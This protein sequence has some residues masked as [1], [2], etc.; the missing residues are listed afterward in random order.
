MDTS[1][2]AMTS[3][4]CT[5]RRT[6]ALRSLMGLTFVSVAMLLSSWAHAQ[7]PAYPPEQ[8]KA[9]FLY[10]FGAYVEWP[11]DARASGRFTI[12]VLGAESIADE[13]RRIAP[14]RTVAD[15]PVEIRHIRSLRELREPQ[16]L[17]VGEDASAQLPAVVAALRGRPVLVVSE[18]P[19]ALKRG[20]SINFTLSDR[21]VRF[22]VSLPQA[23]QAGIELSSRLL[24]VALRV[25]KTGLLY[26]VW[27]RTHAGIRCRYGT[28]CPAR[29]TRNKS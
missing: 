16:I 22:E 10:H 12:T 7:D 17:F 14:G 20:A 25:E 2:I 13:L 11:A 3:R 21:R 15:R 4:R 29:T 18:V 6:S 28:R 19:D 5:M 8:V 23:K 24:S 26:G 1:M 27:E 9:A